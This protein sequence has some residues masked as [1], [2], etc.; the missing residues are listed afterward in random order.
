MASYGTSQS[1]EGQ[2]SNVVVDNPII[3]VDLQATA[4]DKFYFLNNP[5][6]QYVGPYHRHEDGTL[7]IGVGVLGVNHELKPDEIIFEEISDV[8]ILE[9]RE[10]V[11]DIFYKLWFQSNTLSEQEILSIQTT[12]RDG[13]KQTGRTEDEPLVFYKKDRNTLESRKDLQGDVFEQICQY[14]L[15]NNIIDLDGLFSIEEIPGPI[16]DN[17]SSKYFRII[18]SHGTVSYQIRVA[19]KV[20]D[21]FTDVLNL[22]QL[23]KPKTST[24]VNPEK[25]RDVLDTNIFELL[26]NQ[27]TRQDTIN[28]FFNQFNELI[29]PKPAFDDVDGDG[30]GEVA[31]NYDQDEQIRISYANRPTAYITRLDEQ[32][33]GDTNNQDKTLE[34]MR[35]KLNTYLGD[36]DNVIDTLEDNRPEYENISEGFLRIRKPNQAI[37]LRSPNNNQLEFQRVNP[38]TGKP[39]YLE[40]GFTITMW[41]KFVSKTSEGT[42][43]NFGNPLNSN[44]QNSSNAQGFRLDTK[45]NQY[46]GKYYRYIRLVVR[47]WTNTTGAGG[48]VYR[49]RDNNFGTQGLNR[50]DHR[51]FG[52]NVTDYPE[53]HRAFPQISTDNL[54]EWYFIC[55]T[56]NPNIVELD[57]GD[58]PSTFRQDTQYWLNHKNQNGD[59]VSN[60]GVGAK[61][62]VEIISRTDL[63]QARGYRVRPLTVN[64]QLEVVSSF[65][66]EFI[67]DPIEG[68]EDSPPPSNPPVANFQYE[69]L[70]GDA[71]LDVIL[72]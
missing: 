11:S 20:G 69:I 1:T 25:A 58:I 21:T 23:T 70:T 50:F 43:F 10:R 61:C 52:T 32:A 65:T 9:T 72:P 37:I 26:P 67:E 17:Q 18:F 13:I 71:L 49:I 56:F 42:L 36:T 53:V 12:I 28:S 5:D 39:S 14:I 57:Y 6:E 24:R 64:T 47:D 62:K 15:Q 55:A 44:S 68:E 7:M 3:E 2:G 45:V 46:D 30:A 8:N 59:L 16:V 48:R 34:S 29:G 41:V 35:N 38:I 27:T 4:N 66:Y 40:D 19:E 31:V 60:S 33:A 63:L 51:S 22:S 54:D